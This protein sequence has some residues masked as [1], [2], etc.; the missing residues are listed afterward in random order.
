MKAAV[1]Q[2]RIAQ[3]EH[4]RE[5]QKYSKELYRT[6]LD[7]LENNNMQQFGAYLATL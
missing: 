5:Y 6:D 4:P 1:K 7:F 3:V 2:A